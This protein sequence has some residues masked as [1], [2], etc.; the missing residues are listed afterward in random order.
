MVIC[1]VP[2]T[3]LKTSVQ[4]SGKHAHFMFLTAKGILSGGGTTPTSARPCSD[5]RRPTTSMG[6]LRRLLRRRRDGQCVQADPRRLAR[7]V[8]A[9]MQQW[10]HR[11]TDHRRHRLGRRLRTPS[12]KRGS[13]RLLFRCEDWSREVEVQDLGQHQERSCCC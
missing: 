11:P 4:P 1:C 6:T 7:L 2:C 13:L 5:L 10:H 12:G 8:I 9:R 3:H